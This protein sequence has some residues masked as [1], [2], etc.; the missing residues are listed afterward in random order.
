M[1]LKSLDRAYFARVYADTPDPWNFAESAYENEKYRATIDHLG[2]RRFQS[3]F[4]I[5]CSIGVLT[6]MLAR[7]CDRLLSIDLN[8]RAVESARSRCSGLP[9][10]D[11]EL[12]TFPRDL[13]STAFDLVVI[14]EVAYYW[15]DADLRAAIAFCA[16]V[17]SGGLIELVH[18]LPKVDDYVRDGDAVHEAFLA[19][20]RFERL[21]HVRADR[22]RIDI[23]RV[24]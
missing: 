15:S 19:D 16:G 7:R 23:L 8:E 21:R 18:F 5:G 22:Y 4:E 10:V 12:M 17:T 20:P 2:Q 1:D 11:I 24:T 3:G 6:S 9:N 13:P 14:S